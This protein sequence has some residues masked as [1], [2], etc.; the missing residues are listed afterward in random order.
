MAMSARLLT[1][2]TTV[3]PVLAAKAGRAETAKFVGFTQ[4]AAAAEGHLEALGVLEIELRRQAVGRQRRRRRKRGGPD[5]RPPGDDQPTDRAGLLAVV[6]ENGR[7]W[8]RPRRRLDE[9]VDPTSRRQHQGPVAGL[10]RLGRLTVEGH[11]PHLDIFDFDSKN[12]SL[13][14]VDNAKPEA[15][16]RPCRHVQRR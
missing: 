4:S 2:S 11:G 13:G 9:G 12:R 5:R 7:N 6:Q 8:S 3:R 16:I 10:E 15:F 1:A 14:A